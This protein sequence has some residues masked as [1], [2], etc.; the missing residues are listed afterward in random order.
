MIKKEGMN[1]INGLIFLIIG[2]LLDTVIQVGAVV[3]NKITS[4]LLHISNNTWIPIM[5]EI[6]VI[7]IFTAITVY[8]LQ[9]AVRKKTPKLG[10]HPLKLDKVGWVFKGYLM[11]MGANI[12]INL[13]Q[14][15]VLGHQ[16]EAQNQLKLEALARSGLSNIIFVIILG[17]IVAP[18]VEELMFRGIILNYFF[19]EQNWWFNIILSGILFGAYH[20]M[21][22]FSWFAWMQ[23]SL[24]GMILA[25]VYK[26]TKQLQY[27]ML[28][29]LL[30]NGI[31]M[32]SLI[33]A[34]Y[35]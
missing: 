32:L 15:L 34:T 14:A 25:I 11:I 10:I 23:Y 4:K 22:G 6:I 2:S 7:V 27:S 28:L 35:Y 12:V 13:L 16:Q 17:V 21:A 20:M 31:A 26:K 1:W 9:S 18:L 3:T 8:I 33:Y 19:K 29:H 5:F 30:N 24:T